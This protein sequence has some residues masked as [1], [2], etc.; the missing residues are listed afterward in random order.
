MSENKI[1]IDY[2]HFQNLN[3]NVLEL[4]SKVRELTQENERLERL[5]NY[6]KIEA[7]TD[8]ARWMRTLEDLDTL[9]KSMQ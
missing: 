8:H 2:T 3:K 7:N 1:T 9:R 6:W 4:G 5:V